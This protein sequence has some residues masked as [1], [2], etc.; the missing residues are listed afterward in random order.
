MAKD[1]IRGKA[2]FRRVGAAIFAGALCVG[3]LTAAPA[4][5]AQSS[6]YQDCLAQAETEPAAARETAAQWEAIGG[7]VPAR[8][9]AAVALIGLGAEIRAAEILTEIGSGESDL[10]AAD[11]VSA[12]TLAGDLWLRNGQG[13]LARQ[14]FGAALVIAPKSRDGRIGLARVAALE[15]DFGRAI[16]VLSKVVADEGAI[17]G[18]ATLAEVLTLRA[19]AFRASGDPQSALNDAELATGSAPNE[20]LAWFERGAAERALG[21]RDDARESWLRASMLDP[22][23]AAGDLARLNLQRLEVE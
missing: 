15:S 2:S 10:P 7:G 13:L 22:Y 19:A 5:T 12:L 17:G 9:C 20:P 4:A 6:Q 14:S 11:R 21:Q 23:G 3:V 8:H 1:V 18:T 16:E